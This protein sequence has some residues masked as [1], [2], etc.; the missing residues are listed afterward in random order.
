MDP[1]PTERQLEYLQ[2][3]ADFTAEKKFPPTLREIADHFKVKSG[4]VQAALIAL[5]E[6]QMITW[7]PHKSRTYKVLRGVKETVTA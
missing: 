5:R 7:E 6:K 4:S 2:H 1:N 3:V